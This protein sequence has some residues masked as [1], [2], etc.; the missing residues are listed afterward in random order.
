MYT[1]Q[2]KFHQ[3]TTKALRYIVHQANITATALG[4]VSDD[5]AAAKKITVAQVFLP[6]NVQSDIEE[7]QTKLN[8]SAIQLSGRTKENKEDILDI[9]E[10]V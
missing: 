4:N 7:I 8:A 10:R 6:V 9:L 5:L 1:G 3:C 2:W